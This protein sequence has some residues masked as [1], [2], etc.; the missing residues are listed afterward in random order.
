MQKLYAKKNG[1]TN[2]KIEYWVSPPEADGD[3]V[4]PME[5]VLE[6]YA[7]PYNPAVPIICVVEQ[8][9]QSSTFDLGLF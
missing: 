8:P 4:A 9:V 3:F 6:I 5:E 2:R 7:K 1:M